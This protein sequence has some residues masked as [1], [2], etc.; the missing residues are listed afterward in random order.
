MRKNKLHIIFPAM[1]L[2]ASCST[3]DSVAPVNDAVV[4]GVMLPV[5]QRIIPNAVVLS[6]KILPENREQYIVRLAD[7]REVYFI[8][9][10]ALSYNIGDSIHLPY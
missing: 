6:K 5:E 10:P 1:L 7:G 9:S 4:R 8:T 2:L 3:E